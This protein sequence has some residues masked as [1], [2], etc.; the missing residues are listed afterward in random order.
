LTRAEQMA[1]FGII[2]P[3]RYRNWLAKQKGKL[4]DALV[5]E[6][7]AELNA[8]TDEYYEMILENRRQLA[9]MRIDARATGKEQ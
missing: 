5:D 7:L 6:A 3:V 9:Q 1:E 2:Y 8:L 4:H